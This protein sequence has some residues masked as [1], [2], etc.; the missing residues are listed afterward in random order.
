MDTQSGQPKL[1]NS[2]YIKAWTSNFML[3]FSFMLLTPLLP[4]YLS[5]TF[6]ADKQMIGLVLSGYTL[7][8]LI[9]R[10][11]S[12]YMADS[13]PRKTV[14]L[15][16][17]AAF[18]VLFSGYLFAQSLA[19]FAVVRTLHGAPFGATTVC[20]ST[21]AIDVLPSE[22][23]NEGIGYYGLSNNLATAIAPTLAIVIYQS[24]HNYQVLFTLALVFA[25]IGFIIDSTIRLPR[26]ELN[27]EK[28]A[29]S[30]DRFFLLKGWSQGI[31]IACFAFSYGV[32]STYI[33][34]YG[35]EEL[36]ITGGTGL[37]FTLLASGLILSR[38]VGSR[39][40]RQGKITQ[41]ASLGMVISLFGY[42]VFAAIHNRFGYY[43]SAL[44]IGLGNGHMYP[45]FQA[46]FIN[47]APNSQRGTANSTLLTSWDIGVG[48][49]ILAGGWIAESLGYHSA[50][51]GAW[52]I[53]CLGVVWFF[54]YAR[55]HFNRNKLR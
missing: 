24:C 3:F 54:S 41:N 25:A 48:L 55:Q 16:C 9:I 37:F 12:G 30:L 10:P 47:L 39:T 13:F 23:R 15:I 33:A 22:R 11:F 50:F 27:K 26:R 53:N 43:A 20:N 21:V 36:D 17:Y 40:L 2:N 7:T 49:G 34:I 31:D 38:L 32:M 8:A 35:K 5:D 1:W 6:Q 46:M 44:I 45:A 28:R 4:I 19:L 51:W 14:L 42:L 29:V 52:I 18:F